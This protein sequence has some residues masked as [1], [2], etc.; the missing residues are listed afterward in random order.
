MKPPPVNRRVIPKAK[1]CDVVSQRHFPAKT[2]GK[3]SSTG[4]SRV[5]VNCYYY[6][7]Q[8]YI[9]FLATFFKS[10]FEVKLFEDILYIIYCRI[11]L[12]E[13]TFAS[14][15]MD[16]EQTSFIDNKQNTWFKGK[17]VAEILGYNDTD[18][19][20]RKH[21]DSEDKK[22]D[23]DD[24]RHFPVETTGKYRS[25]GRLGVLVNES[26]FYSLILSSKL[27]TAKRIQK[28]GYKCCSAINQKIWLL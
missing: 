8:K 19:A 23:F 25:R 15:E 7:S 14:D 28:M 6:C 21:V 18:Q 12:I 22:C 11:A 20:L 13:K 26:G 27:E 5:L 16:V 1:K 17:E 3:Y 24:Q 10:L 2:A 4:R 9:L